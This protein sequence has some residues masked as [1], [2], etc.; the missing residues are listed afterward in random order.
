VGGG[1]RKKQTKKNKNFSSLIA[2]PEERG[3]GIVPS[4][5]A[6]FHFSSLFFLK[7]HEMTSFFP[8]YVVSFK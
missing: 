5:T 7:M 1:E 2:C 8:K 3:G 4:K 6:L